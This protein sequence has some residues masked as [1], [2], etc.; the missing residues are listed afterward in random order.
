VFVR[1]HGNRFELDGR[2]Y[3]VNG[4]NCYY[5]AHG[6]DAAVQAVFALAGEFGFNVLRAP[7]FLDVPE[8]RGWAWFQSAPGTYNDGPTGLELL[9]RTIQMAESC[10]I[11]LILPLVNNW[12]DFGGM[13]QYLKWLG[14]ES[15]EDFYRAASAR[16]AYRSWVEHVLLRLNTRT[17]RQYRDEPAVMAWEL[18]NE[19]RC[20]IPGGCEVLLEW[21]AEMSQFVKTLDGNHLVALG[22]EGFFRRSFTRKHTHNGSHGVD[23]EALMGIGTLDFG[24]AHLY[25]EW[26]PKEPA[27]V[28]GDRWIRDHVAAAERA[29]KPMLIEEYGVKGDPAGRDA[30][31]GCW[32][33]AV[34]EGSGA[35]AMLWMIAATDEQGERY[36]DY[37]GYTVY[38]TAEVPSVRRQRI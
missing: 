21:A 12:D 16:Q 24:V 7:A 38:S 25:P 3:P 26:E 19:P 37:D 32:W 22:D 18:A 6:S 35:G 28:F 34:E 9:D 23:T 5:A 30:I 10:G 2:P 14:L 4:G 11:R 13:A 33:K 36:P 20:E 8:P 29:N 15:H 27:A 1:A 17:G 31:F